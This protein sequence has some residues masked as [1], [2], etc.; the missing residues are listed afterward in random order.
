MMHK[1]RSAHGTIRGKRNWWSIG[2][3]PRRRWSISSCR[4]I[5]ALRQK[6]K[7]NRSVFFSS[8][9]VLLPTLFFVRVYTSIIWLVWCGCV[10]IPLPSSSSYT[11]F[12][13]SFALF[14]VF[15]SRSFFCSSPTSL[16]RAMMYDERIYVHIFI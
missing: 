2:E 6:V 1:S 8:W 15:S 11:F 16:L 9:Y 7:E 10:K 13:F 14:Y 3:I 5:F 4:H 12:S